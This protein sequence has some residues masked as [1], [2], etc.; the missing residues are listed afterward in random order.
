MAKTECFSHEI[1]NKANIC[2]HH[3]FNIVMKAL[4]GIREEKNKGIRIGKE[5][6][7]PICR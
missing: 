1:S 6:N 7:L 2:S 5:E 4:P 3:S